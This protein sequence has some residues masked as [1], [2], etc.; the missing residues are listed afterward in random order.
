MKRWLPYPLLAAGI[1]VMW[2]LLT[3][4][5]SPG[6]VLLGLAVSLVASAGMM[7]LRHPATRIQSWP[8]LIE[9]AFVVFVDIVRSNI[10]VVR[11]ALTPNP[12]RHSQFIRLNVRLRDPQALTILALI[13]TATPGTAWVQYNRLDG[14]LLIHIFDLV[15]EEAWIRLI[16]YRY[17]RLLMEIFEG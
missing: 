13:I 11:I 7:R 10:A 8:K 12:K 16:E 2:L 6:Q 17:E 1:F 15:D 5:F 9:L 4:S 3:Q 14:M